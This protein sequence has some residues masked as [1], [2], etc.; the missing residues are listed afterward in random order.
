MNKNNNK[1]LLTIITSISIFLNSNAF[2]GSYTIKDLG[3]LGGNHSYASALNNNGIVVGL[4]NTTSGT[5]S[6]YI[7]ENKTMT[8]ITSNFGNSYSTAGDINDSNTVL[9]ST[10]SNSFIHQDG[11]NTYLSFSA[12]L[13]EINNSGQIIGK[14]NTGIL[15]EPGYAFIY[16]NGVVT[17]LDTLVGLTDITPLAITDDGTIAF[18]SNGTTY[19]YQ[20]NSLINLPFN[21][22]MDMSNQL[23]ILCAYID[24]DGKRNV[25]RYQNGVMEKLG[26]YNGLAT[27]MLSI[28]NQGS[29]AGFA[30]LEDVIRVPFE[31]FY[32]KVAVMMLPD[33]SVVNLN[34]LKMH[35][36]RFDTLL[37]AYDINQS[38]QI[39]GT[40]LINGEVHGFLLTPPSR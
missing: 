23:Q 4:S 14:T 7:Y 35:G 26:D 29:A 27:W 36:A 38:G 20:N 25:C 17:R 12:G 6:A 10:Q 33:G 24:T 2:A 13:V 31:P 15:G 1:V 9:V 34:D 19:L 28:N 22:F 32:N 40:G 16:E 5:N 30:I 39:V 11:V 3:T 8:E 21:G 18:S 37:E